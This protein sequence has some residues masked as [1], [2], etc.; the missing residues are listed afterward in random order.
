MKLLYKLIFLFLAIGLSGCASNVKLKSQILE[1]PVKE[2]LDLDAKNYFNPVGK[3]KEV[4]IKKSDVDVQKIGTYTM[5][6][7]YENKDYNVKI[8]IID[9]EKP[10]VHCKKKTLVFPLSTDLKTVNE[11]IQNNVAIT[12][13]YDKTFELPKVSKIPSS[14]SEVIL[15]IKVKDKSGNESDETKL[16]LQ[17]TEDGKKQTNLSSQEEKT[18][19]TAVKDTSKSKKND[20]VKQSNNNSISKQENVDNSK[21]PIQEKP[22]KQPSQGIQNDNESLEKEEVVYP[23]EELPIMT[24]DNFPSYLLGNSGRVFATYEEASSWAEEQ[25]SIPGG[26]WEDCIMEIIQPFDGNY[27]NAGQDDTPWTV[28]FSTMD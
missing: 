8:K 6:I 23:E 10:V 20:S 13:N 19:L 9:K 27:A 4:V 14:A 7:Q 26:P 5:S 15:R 17:F 11:T 22:V 18:S 3:E 25:T 12:D 16:T 28:N 21:S 1:F 24:V 2:E